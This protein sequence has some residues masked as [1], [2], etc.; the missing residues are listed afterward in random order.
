MFNL[1]ADTGTNDQIPQPP[2]LHC[3]T[4]PRAPRHW[5]RRTFMDLEAC[6]SLIMVGL[7][8]RGLEK[9]MLLHL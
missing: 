4:R 2:R 7:R 6:F 5:P 1:N 8:I 9:M 3:R